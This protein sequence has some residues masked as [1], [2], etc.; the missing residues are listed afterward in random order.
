MPFQSEE[1]VDPTPM[2]FTTGSPAGHKLDLAAEVLRSGGTIRLEALGT[3]M[4]PS[5]WPGD[6]L[7][8]ESKLGEETVPGDIVLVARDQRFFIHRLVEKQ[9][10]LWI[11]RGDSLPQNDDPV[12][13]SQ[14]LGKVSAIH[15]RGDAVA[16]GRRLSLLH[17]ALA[18]MLCHCDSIRNIALRVHS[19]QQRGSILVAPPSRR[20]S[21]GR[22]RPHRRGQD[23]LATAGK[24]PAL[25]E[26]Q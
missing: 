13:E 15:R 3:S 6:V 16:S 22:P 19:F 24:M 5:I 11:T 17:R 7:R 4:L 8:I 10:S 23:A 26:P 9:D 2:P 1:F 14:V 18:G 12:A 20:L 21:W 25:Q